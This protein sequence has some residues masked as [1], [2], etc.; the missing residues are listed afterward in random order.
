MCVASC[1]SLPGLG[2]D[3]VRNESLCADGAMLGVVLGVYPG[4]P[5]AIDAQD[6][7]FVQHRQLG[8]DEREDDGCVQEQQEA[9]MRAVPGGKRND[10]K[11]GKQRGAN[12]EDPASCHHLW[13]PKRHSSVVASGSG[14]HPPGTKKADNP[15]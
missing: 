5:L 4:R 6:P 8:D 15:V 10:D 9:R 1:D 11:P 14:V 2:L 12:Q 3:P 13:P 7:D